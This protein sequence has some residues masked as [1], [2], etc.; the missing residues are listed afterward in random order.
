M[1]KK[2]NKG[3]RVIQEKKKVHLKREDSS[4]E[5]EKNEKT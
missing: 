4:D 2:S 5:E 3:E 1:M